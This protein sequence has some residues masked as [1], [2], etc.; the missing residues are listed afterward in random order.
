MYYRG[1]VKRPHE[2]KV[3]WRTF[4]VS[5]S[6]KREHTIVVF[7]SQHAVNATWRTFNVAKSLKHGHMIVEEEELLFVSQWLKK[8]FATTLFFSTLCKKVLFK[9]ERLTTTKISINKLSLSLEILKLS[10][11]EKEQ[12]CVHI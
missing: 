2:L 4:N 12:W 3:T 11:C 9:E 7:V 6:L 1:W 8:I 5:K 10:I